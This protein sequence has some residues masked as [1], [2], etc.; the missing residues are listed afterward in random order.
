M[1]RSLIL[2]AAVLLNA[3]CLHAQA[4][5]RLDGAPQTVAVIQGQVTLPGGNPVPNVYL[6]LEPEGVGGTVQSA[7]TDSSG[8]F[9]FSGAI[10]GQNYDVTGTVEGFQPIDKLVMLNGNM[11]YVYITLVPLAATNAAVSVAK[12]KMRAAIPPKAEEQFN[13][14]LESMD[15]G[16]TSDAEKDFKNA[17]RIDPKFAPAFLRLSM[18]YAERSH[19]PEAERAIHRA[20]AID[21]DSPD[22]Y[23]YSGYLYMEEKQPEKAEQSFQKSLHMA[24]RNWFAQLEMGRLLYGQK[25]YLGALPH[26]QIARRLH[27]QFASVH[28]LL[29]DDL[30]RLGRYKGA[31][32]ELDDFVAH[33]PK[34]KEAPQMRKVRPALAAAAAKQRRAGS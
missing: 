6:Q 34:S 17:V 18:I 31:L 29:Y 28:L 32:A 2:A 20:M 25:N 22:N 4:T 9:S 23:A 19:F 12:L 24:P 1:K 10:N 8:N 33:F 15:R 7:T 5:G 16:K 26:L 27:P 30:I 21:K 13:K 14:G 3:T 11:T